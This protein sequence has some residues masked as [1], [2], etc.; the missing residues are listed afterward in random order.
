MGCSNSEIKNACEDSESINSYQ[1]LQKL[2][3][4]Y[5]N[6]IQEYKIF[7]ETYEEILEQELLCKKYLDYYFNL[8]KKV[9]L[10]NE[11]KEIQNYQKTFN[12]VDR[13]E[14]KLNISAS[15]LTNFKFRNKKINNKNDTKNK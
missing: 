11:P 3:A 12:R 4:Q 9:I 1:K 6:A 14:E 15:C 13:L 7:M 5:K 2:L 10:T 8:Q